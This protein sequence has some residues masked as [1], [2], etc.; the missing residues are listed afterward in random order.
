MDFKKNTQ[1]LTW[2]INCL[3]W[4]TMAIYEWANLDR[5]DAVTWEYICVAGYSMS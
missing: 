2:L 4:A 1:T 5:S 3:I